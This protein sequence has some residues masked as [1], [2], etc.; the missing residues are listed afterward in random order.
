METYIKLDLQLFADGEGAGDSGSA[1]DAA[2]GV[3]SADAEHEDRLRALGVP[4]S[5]IQK[6]RSYKSKAARAEATAPVQQTAP[7]DAAS[8]EATPEEATTD[9]SGQ[10]MNWD[11]IM[12]DPEYKEQFD[13]AANGIVRARLGEANN[14]VAAMKSLT[15]MLEV[16]ARKYGMDMK[17]ID[18]DAL[19]KSVSNEDE[20]YEEKAM[21]MGTDVATARAADQRERDETRQQEE[22]A[23]AAT[24]QA[25][26][27][28]IA[29]LR[30]QE[31][32]LKKTFPNFS[33]DEELKD[34]RFV[35][36]TA[37]GGG[38]SLEDAFYAVHRKEIQA[39]SAQVV[40]QR[41]AQSI[42]QSIQAGQ[43]RPQERRN[44]QTTVNDF[45]KMS[46]ADIKEKIAMAKRSGKK[47]YPDGSMR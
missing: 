44:T 40:A 31:V 28:H 41:T 25:I 42:S 23:R 3:E 32:E 19:C 45:N 46:H 24:Q 16:L 11:Q 14:A 17:N 39:A 35:R 33:L 9:G 4:E 36:M 15:P 38:W 8:E 22:Q 37:P 13:K 5:K 6:Q 34:P 2:P 7:D 47:F 43:M 12:S 1:A 21:E 18:Y 26:D 30:Q 29:A 10:R 27:S 20:F